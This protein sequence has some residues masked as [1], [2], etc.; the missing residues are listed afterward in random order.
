MFAKVSI[1]EVNVRKFFSL[2]PRMRV[3]V[4]IGPIAT[5]MWLLSFR[6]FASSNTRLTSSRVCG[7]NAIFGISNSE[8]LS[9]SSLCARFATGPSMTCRLLMILSP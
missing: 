7:M 2:A 9:S 1:G 3:G 8:S 5:M 6:F 4:P